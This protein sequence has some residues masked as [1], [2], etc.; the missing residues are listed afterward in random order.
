MSS[1]TQYLTFETQIVTPRAYPVR[2]VQVFGL[3]TL[4]HEQDTQRSKGTLVHHVS[5]ERS[6]LS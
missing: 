6:K 3:W 1:I 4:V 5:C 2:S